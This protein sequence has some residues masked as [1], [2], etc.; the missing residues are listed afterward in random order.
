MWVVAYVRF[1]SGLYLGPQKGAAI[2]RTNHV[3]RY[4]VLVL[5]IS[6]SGCHDQWKSTKKVCFLVVLFV[7]SS[8]SLEPSSSKIGE[9][10]D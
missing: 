4:R 1:S 8:L 7:W 3:V 9:V 10:S 6:A 2:A 5:R